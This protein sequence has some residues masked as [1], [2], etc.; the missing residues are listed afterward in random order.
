[1]RFSPF[2]KQCKLI[3]SRLDN[4]S[5]QIAALSAVQV[6]T[7]LS[8]Q[9]IN[10]VKLLNITAGQKYSEFEKLINKLYS[11]IPLPD[12]LDDQ[13]VSEIQDTISDQFVLIQS[14]CHT[15]VPPPAP[16]ESLNDSNASASVH[17][18]TVTSTVKL[19]PLNL[20]TF[21]GQPDQWMCF[22]GLFENAVHNNSTLSNT[23][24]FTYLLSCLSDEPLS[25][26]KFLP[27]TTANYVI[28]WQTLTNRYHNTRLLVTL[29]TNNLLDLPQLNKP[30][31]K[32][33]RKFI[34]CY[35]ENYHA[36][37]ALGH[38][39]ASESLLLTSHILRKLEPELRS[40]FEQTRTDC[41]VVPNINELIK[42]LENECSQQ[43]AVTLTNMS[44][45][46]FTPQTPSKFVTPYVKSTSSKP[47]LSNVVMMTSTSNYTP[48]CLYCS[49]AGHLI[50]KCHKFAA[51]DPK[52]RFTF[53]RE[54]DLC[55]NCFG[56]HKTEKCKSSQSC[57]SCSKRHH[58]L[59]HFGNQSIPQTK[60]NI[61]SGLNNA[62]LHNS[63]PVATHSIGL[64][65]N[66]SETFVGVT[67]SATNTVLLATALVHAT[68]QDGHSIVIRAVLDSA[69]Q[70]TL[71]TESC[72]TLLNAKRSYPSMSNISGISAAQV[73]PKGFTFVTIASLS[74]NTLATS[75]PTL[76]LDKIS[77]ELPRAQLAPNVKAQMKGYV[78]ADPTFD[79][80]GPVDMLIGADLFPLTITGTPIS[81]G[82]NLP[83]IINTIFGYVALGSAPL[84]NTQ[85]NFSG[86]T[87]LLSTND[88]ELHSTLKQFWTIEEPPQ[89]TK[90][91]PL[92]Q[93]CEAHFKS[94]HSRDNLTGKYICRL[95][96]KGDPAQL[97]DSSSLAKQ[98][99]NSL[100][101]RFSKQPEF[102]Q[103]YVEFMKD[104]LNSNHMKLCESIPTNAKPHFFI[105]H[106]G[107]FKGDKL[108]V[109]FN[110]SAPTSTGVSLND[111][112]H[113]GPKL[114]NDICDIIFHFRQH[115]IVFS[116]DIKQMFR[117]ILI[118]DEDQIFQLIY[119]RENLQDPLKVYQLTT[120]TYGLASSPY[121]ANK[122]IQQLIEDEKRNH[123][124]AANALCQN[125]FVDD[126]LLGSDSLDDAQ[127]LKTDL[128]DL[129]KKGGFELRKWSSNCP[130][131]LQDMPQDYC[132]TPLILRSENQ[133][134]HSILGIK[135]N[136][137]SD[138]FS[139]VIKNPSD[140]LT[141]RSVLSAIAQIYDPI[142]ILSPLVF[143]AK[144]LMQHLWCLGL[145]WDTPLPDTV[146]EKWLKFIKELPQIEQLKIPRYLQLSNACNVQLH[147]FADASELGFASCV[148]AR[149]ENSEQISIH[150]LIAKS[151][152]APLKRMTI[153]RLELCA[154]H[155]LSKLLHYCLE[156]MSKK[157]Q[158]N[159]MYA[160]SDST[161]ALSWI[162]TPS[163]RLKLF[164]GNRVAQIQELIPTCTWKHISSNDNPADC[165][166][167]GLTATALLNHEL[168][169]SGPKWLI[170]DPSNWPNATLSPIHDGCAS[171]MKN[172][173]NI[174]IST[175]VELSDFLTKFSSWEKLK[176]VLAY[177]LRFINCL[178]SKQKIVHSITHKELEI[179][180]MKI[181]AHIQRIHF[182]KEIKSL[183][184]NMECST[185]IQRLAPF[186]D[187]NGL[188]RVGGR[189]KN[190]KLAYGAKYPILLPKN[191]VIVHNLIDYYHKKHL[192]AG[193]L[194]LQSI[195]QQM[196]W[197]LSGRSVI[198]SRIFKCLRCFK[199]KPPTTAP[200]MGDL[201]AGRVTPT[202]CFNVSAVDFAGPYT[203]RVQHLRRLTPVKAYLCLFICFAS[204]AVHLELVSDLS[205]DAF[206]AALTR[207]ISRRGLVTDLHS[208]C[209]TN[210][211]GTASTLKKC[212]QDLISMPE[213]QRFAENHQIRFHFNPPR[214]PHQGGLWE[215]AIKS[216]KHHL[217]RVIGESIL[218]YEEFLTLLARVES[219]LNSR[220][221][222]PLSSDPSD[223]EALTPGHFLTGGPLVSLI[224]PH[225][226]DFSLNRLKRWK[227]VQAF[228][229]H[230]WKRW[231]QEYLQNLQERSKWTVSKKNLNVGDLVVIHEDNTPPLAWKLGRVIRLCPGQ[232][233]IVRVIEVKTQTRT[234]TRPAIKVSRLP[235]EQ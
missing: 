208:D 98:M 141:K 110:G 8:E 105:P 121:N 195:L 185:K 170:H 71:I 133:P 56:T 78:L 162:R 191:H 217:T 130:E 124:L 41:K 212:F 165:A 49:S 40:K 230:I 5:K 216:A 225:L 34:S 168:W 42:F 149:V 204:K 164:V 63:P 29:H 95:P 182:P 196:F 65:E 200:L 64:Q 74:G 114:H 176:R 44:N 158:V 139:Y 32:Q 3:E 219:M 67:C 214:A 93:E 153:P 14:T 66:Q 23:E 70:S 103:K 132:E 140:A 187:E 9:Q 25:L 161:V 51:L 115:E 198:R 28:A 101:K 113:Q 234:F 128:I 117:N 188:I 4:I 145:D 108:R 109:V 79:V 144:V 151:K 173:R 148:Y 36:L 107:I 206:I 87:T 207:F 104:Y 15:L 180:S 154:A 55:R 68:T 84:S 45:K 202:R 172:E 175:E 178:K 138:D 197:I 76:I 106:H 39:V 21:S 33:L 193:P 54:K 235:L 96:F 221:I 223:F 160:W 46:T 174:L 12:D 11:T 205:S 38:D 179:A 22:Y 201:P 73:K 47:K 83:F 184:Q 199:T 89:A 35:N 17:T 134:T 52:E 150:L 181:L 59:L 127:Q 86:L 189:L 209:G 13:Q 31:V 131:L 155:L 122:V 112:Q 135:W 7:S 85:L 163:Y 20:G 211:V 232:D 169:W 167:R 152:V 72:A 126:A 58:T 123:P 143:W 186:L 120:V 26:I 228:S 18:P 53:I 116:C 6:T 43:E 50:Y 37:K 222:T 91:S 2:I 183:K 227:L 94:N 118:H 100:E 159:A 19:P 10:K 48:T 190:S 81:L 99:F 75:H 16:P 30:S 192:H 147:A 226:T 61:D 80:P 88:L 224:E 62:T 137:L 213:T 60:P 194:Q 125:I 111:I 220:P 136:P 157:L 92:D 82:K 90:I 229:Q 171:E 27:V 218:T 142:G 156:Q 166:S 102:K 215:R 203:I 119:W 97:G 77:N 177:I 210:F 146:S 231:S 1:M 129:M 69:S 24:K 233:G 57:R